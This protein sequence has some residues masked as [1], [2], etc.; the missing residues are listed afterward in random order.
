MLGKLLKSIKA[1]ING[2]DLIDQSHISNLRLQKVYELE[3]VNMEGRPCYRLHTKLGFGS[4]IGEVIVDDESISPRHC[5][6][7]LDQNVISIIDHN[8]VTGTLVNNKKIEP[9]KKLIL[10]ESDE[11]QIGELLIRIK[12]HNEAVVKEKK[13]SLATMPDVEEFDT[14][15]E[16]ATYPEEDPDNS[17]LIAELTKLDEKFSDDVK[18]KIDPKSSEDATSTSVSLDEY[19]TV[20]DKVGTFTLDEISGISIDEL[21]E[22]DFEEEDIEEPQ[23]EAEENEVEEEELRKEKKEG[24]SFDFNK[25]FSWLKFGKKGQT[26]FRKRSKKV[27]LVKKYAANTIL[28]VVALHVD[29]CF[30]YGTYLLLSPFD[31]FKNFISMVISSGKILFEEATQHPFYQSHYS[32]IS[33]IVEMVSDLWTFIDTYINPVPALILVMISKLIFTALLGVSLGQYVVGMRAEGNVI[34]KRIG[35]VLRTL[36]GFVTFP[37]LI[38]DIGSIISRRTFKEVITFTRLYSDSKMMS[39]LLSVVFVFV[40]GVY[41]MMAPMFQGF[42]TLPSYQIAQKIEERVRLQD[43]EGNA[44]ELPHKFNTSFLGFQVEYSDEFEI[45]PGFRFEGS[46]SKTNSQFVLNFFDRKM[47]GSSELSVVKNFDLKQLL[48]IGFRG[49][50]FLKLKFPH[51]DNYLNQ[52]T[53][54]G[55][56]R[57]VLDSE[58][59]TEEFMEFHRMAMDM[60]IGS[61][62]NYFYEVPMVNSLLSYK[63][64][65][66]SLFDEADFTS[67]SFVRIGNIVALKISQSTPSAHDFIIPILPEGRIMK[68][69]FKGNNTSGLASRLYR[70]ALYKSNWTQEI[71]STAFDHI[72]NALRSGQEVSLDDAQAL[73]GYYYELSQKILSRSDEEEYLLL[74]QSVT[75]V[76]LLID[77]VVK[78]DSNAL[79][80]LQSNFKDLVDAV[81]IRNLEYFNL[82]NTTVL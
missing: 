41:V 73:Y 19:S 16:E 58:S 39:I 70:Y 80:K 82:T 60:S 23:E 17:E 76:Q 53:P 7:T 48:E 38:F 52:Y 26:S 42:E 13:A 24:S 12:T 45:L 81:D 30:A 4:Q 2:G 71:Q 56:K 29:L 3:L 32:D 9:G 69:S 44:E 63:Q 74:K 40:S 20:G 75:S 65:F 59:F 1:P 78:E 8:S 37:F 43:S 54:V 5:T 68:V 66:L 64:S 77:S 33:F 14:E 50:P 51:I 57:S 31:D 18:L 34:W 49:N 25:M 6:F 46:G 36:I 28:R 10:D 55:F 79:L 47:N 22:Q 15:Y 35:G 61:F 67:M 72:L 62:F 27:V 21:L 11:V